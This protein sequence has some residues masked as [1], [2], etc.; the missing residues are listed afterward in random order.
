MH[1]WSSATAVQRRSSTSS[2]GRFCMVLPGSVSVVNVLYCGS[3]VK[4]LRGH[5]L[6]RQD[7]REL[8]RADFATGI[9]RSHALK[10][11]WNSLSMDVAVLVNSLHTTSTVSLLHGQYASVKWCWGAI[12]P[13]KTAQNNWDG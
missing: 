10:G 12:Y 13:A 5:L 7:I 4:T 6:P 2:L 3:S 9:S 8:L 1:A 11:S